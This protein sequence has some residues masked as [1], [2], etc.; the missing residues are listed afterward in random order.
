MRGGQGGVGHVPR[1][2]RDAFM[3]TS[4]EA[5]AQVKQLQFRRCRST[6]DRAT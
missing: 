6:G 1:L 3:A 2:M 4:V 5:V